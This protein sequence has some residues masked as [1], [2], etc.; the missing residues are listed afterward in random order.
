VHKKA[1]KG[2]LRETDISVA[3]KVQLLNGKSVKPGQKMCLRCITEISKHDDTPVYQ[4]HDEDYQ[5][6]GYEHEKARESLNNSFLAL[7]CSPVKETMAQKEAKRKLSQGHS[8]LTDHIGKYAKISSSKLIET[9]STCVKCTDFEKL[10][11]DLKQ[12]CA[13]SSVQK[14][15][16][17]LTLAP[18]SWSIK[19][20]QR[21]SMSLSTK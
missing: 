19:K 4:D 9:P 17:L 16:T 18:A 5:P 6:T 20:L 7:G 14:Q 11:H 21:Y 8:A 15:I 2:S 13:V 10:I 12:K 1:N 3:R